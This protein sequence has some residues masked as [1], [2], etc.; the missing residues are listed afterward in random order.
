VKTVLFDVVVGEGER[1]GIPWQ[2]E[3][4]TDRRDN[5]DCKNAPTHL[6]LQWA[7]WN[8]LHISAVGDDEVI[9]C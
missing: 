7:C 2:R 8:C 6:M 5:S 9:R 1:I 3:T 4:V